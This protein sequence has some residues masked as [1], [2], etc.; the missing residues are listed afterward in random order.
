MTTIIADSTQETSAHERVDRVAEAK[1][2]DDAQATEKAR[3]ALNNLGVTYR[4]VAMAGDQ[5][6][7]ILDSAFEL[8][9]ALQRE[10]IPLADASF[11]K[12]FELLV[13]T[14]L[15]TGI[16]AFLQGRFDELRA[17][18][19]AVAKDVDRPWQSTVQSSQA[20]VKEEG[21]ARAATLKTMQESDGSQNGTQTKT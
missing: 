14:P 8:P 9:C 13:S 15:Q 10:F 1:K 2:Q 7:I 19:K 5:P 18:T 12:L 16:R 21:E 20:A 3:C 11:A 17:Q 6:V 4:I